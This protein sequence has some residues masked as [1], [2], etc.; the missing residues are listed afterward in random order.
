MT[1]YFRHMKNIFDK[2]GVIVTSENKKEID[3]LLHILVNVEYKQCPET[4]KAIKVM[5][6]GNEEEKDRFVEMLKESIIKE[7]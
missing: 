2:V 1:C 7:I 6:Q 4:W 3:R 5:I